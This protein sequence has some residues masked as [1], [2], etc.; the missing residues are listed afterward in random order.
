MKKEEK[1]Y[2]GFKISPKLKEEFLNVLN[3]RDIKITEFF[4]SKVREEVNFHE[5][6]KLKI[7]NS[8]DFWNEFI[9]KKG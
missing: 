7:L 9:N 3:K 6:E 5:K 2:I 4:I 8:S 1:V